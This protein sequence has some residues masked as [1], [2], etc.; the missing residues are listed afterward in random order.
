MCPFCVGT[1]VVGDVAAAKPQAVV[2]HAFMQE[3]AVEPD[4]RSGWH[5]YCNAVF[6][7][8]TTRQLELVLL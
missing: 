5:F 8:D 2:V 3:M 1:K 4:D 6:V 7:A